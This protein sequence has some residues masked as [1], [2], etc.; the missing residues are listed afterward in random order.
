M[1]PTSFPS[2]RPPVKTNPFSQQIKVPLQQ[3]IQMLNV[4]GNPTPVQAIA[5]AAAGP[6]QDLGK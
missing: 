4:P 6:K 5:A 1:K 2:R 3:A